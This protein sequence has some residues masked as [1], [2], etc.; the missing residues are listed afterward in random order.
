MAISMVVW[1]KP[2]VAL[3][4]SQNSVTEGLFD[5]GVLVC[6][7]VC[8][9]PLTVPQQEVRGYERGEGNFDK[10]VTVLVVK[11]AFREKSTT[12]LHFFHR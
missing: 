4:V 8:I 6:V 1:F 12:R 5:F 11:N 2:K 10:G 7:C 3:C 9:C